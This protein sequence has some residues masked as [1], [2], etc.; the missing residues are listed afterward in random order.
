MRTEVRSGMLRPKRRRSACDTPRALSAPLL[1]STCE[2]HTSLFSALH[3]ARRGTLPRQERMC[4]RM[5]ACVNHGREKAQVTRR[6]A[7]SET[8]RDSALATARMAAVGGGL[9][10]AGDRRGQ[11]GVR[12]RAFV[13][14]VGD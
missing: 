14:G 7:I 12:R 5:R 8:R 6:W 1:I 3:A 11:Q 4:W 10:W 13:S 9:R 2:G